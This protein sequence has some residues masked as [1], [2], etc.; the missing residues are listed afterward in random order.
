MARSL[1]PATASIAP[2][3]WPAP[4][5]SSRLRGSRPLRLRADL[6]FPEEPRMNETVGFIGLGTMGLPMASNLAKAGVRLIVHDTSAAARDA[7]PKGGGG[8][9][10]PAAADR[11]PPA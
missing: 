8:T 3:R 9:V 6:H 10:T 7:P 4:N 11:A 2:P 5:L 1:S